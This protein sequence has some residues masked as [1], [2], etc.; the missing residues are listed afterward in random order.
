MKPPAWYSQK[1]Y[2][3]VKSNS[4]MAS[5][6][7]PNYLYDLDE[8]IK[9]YNFQKV[10][11]KVHDESGKT[12]REVAK[13]IGVHEVTYRNHLSGAGRADFGELK[14]LSKIYGVDFLQ[15]AFDMNL[16]FVMKKKVTK[17]PRTLTRYL[18][19]YVGYLQGDGYIRANRTSIG[20]SDEYLSQCNQMDILTKNLF[21]IGGMM[22][23]GKSIIAKKLC[24]TLVVNSRIVNSFIHNCFGINRGVKNELRIPKLM[25]A[26]K[27]LL[28]IYISGLY[29]ADG[30]LPKHPDKVVQFFLDI[31]MKDKIFMQEI[32]DVLKS[33]GIETLKLYE[34]VANYPT[35]VGS[36][37]AWEI[38]IRRRA[39]MLKFLQIIGFR[40]PDKLRRQKELIP[41]L[42]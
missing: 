36:S 11:R 2:K 6:P 22:V 31:T 30:T 25:F 20:F 27:E 38:R 14:K 28:K 24:Y 10:L 1:D 34:R 15:I 7:L 21:G 23:C 3:F 35:G 40:H 26:N 33:F 13:E 19:Y 4:S 37:S 39:E 8:N 41:M 12:I 42:L 5:V 9:V 32:K 16:A 17:L 29:D 18:A